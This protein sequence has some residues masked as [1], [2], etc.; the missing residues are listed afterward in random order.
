MR[1]S[2]FC[3][4]TLL[5]TC[6]FPVQAV[7]FK[8]AT[9]A[10]DGTRW[11]QEMRA[12]AE[13]I[14]ERSGGRVKFRFFPGGTMGNDKSV[15]RKIRVGQLQ[16]GALTAGG[17]SDIAPGSQ[18]YSLPLAFRSLQEV[19]YVRQHMDR[20][21]LD[22]LYKQGFVS[23]GLSETGFAYLMSNRPL[24]RAADLKVQKIWIP[25]GDA[26][27]RAGFVALDV[28]AV[29]LPLSDVLTGL[30]TGLIDTFATS[31]VGA[32]ALQWYTHAQYVT[33][34]PLLYLYGT[35][36]VSR[37]TFDRLGADDQQIVREVLQG[38]SRKLN[39]QSRLDN[40]QAFTAL[41]KQGMQFVTTSPADREIWE[42]I[43]GRA[44]DR[45][46]AEGVIEPTRLRALRQHVN[47]Y[48]RQPAQ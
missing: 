46:A 34:I 8:I 23:F 17:L 18:I 25:E 5:L 32:I 21:I 24:A 9:L 7:T 15:L 27:S 28:S 42:D 36:I 26:I 19:D 41:G 44:M 45:L 14:Q 30:Q 10:P 43:V 47:D 16:G 31:P 35:L 4:L 6:L 1:L 39:E 12:A 37:Q 20:A 40:E 3:L 2:P 29:P 13:A 22:E 38:I 33:E 48:R 11:M